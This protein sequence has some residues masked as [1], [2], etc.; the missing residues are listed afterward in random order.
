[1]T[2]LNFGA[3]I[4]YLPYFSFCHSNS[5]V[6]VI[7]FLNFLGSIFGEAEAPWI[8]KPVLLKQMKLPSNSGT[9]GR[10]S[11]KGA[12]ALN[13]LSMVLELSYAFL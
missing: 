2:N 8:L 5:L 4:I 13:L 12:N 6:P 9:T 10:I 11:E 1:M 3:Y 7:G